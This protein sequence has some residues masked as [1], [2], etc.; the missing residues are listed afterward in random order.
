MRSTVSGMCLVD[1]SA[2]NVA[3]P[4]QLEFGTQDYSFNVF[5]GRVSGPKLLQ[6]D[7]DDRVRGTRASS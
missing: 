5:Q 3:E 1:P 7:P 2:A 6:I 4:C